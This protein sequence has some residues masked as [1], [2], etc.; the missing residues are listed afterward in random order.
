MVRKELLPEILAAIP[1]ADKGEHFANRAR[2]RTG[3]TCDG[4]IILRYSC[5]RSGY[6]TPF[7]RKAGG[8]GS[9]AG[10]MDDVDEAGDVPPQGGA[11]A[12]PSPPPSEGHGGVGEPLRCGCS[13]ATLVEYPPSR[14]VPWCIVFTVGQHAKGCD[15]ANNNR[16]LAMYQGLW[17]D[18]HMQAEPMVD[19]VIRRNIQLIGEAGLKATPVD[20]EP[21]PLL[22]AHLMVVVAVVGAQ[23]RKL[24]NLFD[25]CVAFRGMAVCRPPNSAGPGG[26]QPT[27]MRSDRRA[28]A[29]VGGAG[30]AERTAGAGA[31]V[32]APV[33]AAEPA[34]VDRGRAALAR[35][36][37]GVKRD[38]VAIEQSQPTDE[39]KANALRH[40]QFLKRSCMTQ[41]D[42]DELAERAELLPGGSAH[43]AAALLGV[44]PRYSYFRRAFTVRDV[45]HFG[46]RLRE[47]ARNGVSVR[48]HLIDRLQGDFA[49][50][51]W[52]KTAIAFEADGTVKMLR[53]LIVTPLMRY[54]ATCH[55]G[56]MDVCLLDSTFGLSQFSLDFFVILLIHP[57]T[58]LAL[59]AGIFLMLGGSHIESIKV[60]SMVL[61]WQWWRE[62]ASFI[63]PRVI[64]QDKDKGSWSALA[65]ALQQDCA[66][67]AGV[68]ALASVM[69]QLRALAEG[70]TRQELEAADACLQAYR[71]GASF[72]STDL[73]TLPAERVD[74]ARLL[75]RGE[76][77]ERHP[78]LVRAFAFRMQQTIKGTIERVAAAHNWAGVDAALDPARRLQFLVEAGTELDTFFRRFLVHHAMLCWFHAKKAILEHVWKKQLVPREQQELWVD[79]IFPA[80][81]KLFTCANEDELNELWADLQARYI[82]FPEMIKYLMDNWMC[83]EWRVMWA[84]P[85][86]LQVPHLLIN[87]TNACELFFNVM[88]NHV[89]GAR[90]RIDMVDV[91]RKVF[92]LPGEPS[93]VR[94]SMAGG[95]HLKLYHIMSPQAYLKRPSRLHRDLV[96]AVLAAIDAVPLAVQALDAPQGVYLVATQRKR[97]QM[98]AEAVQ[99]AGALPANGP[100]VANADVLGAAVMV[101]AGPGPDVVML[102]VAPPPAVYA[103]PAGFHICSVLTNICS[104]PSTRSPCECVLSARKLHLR[105]RRRSM[106]FDAELSQYYNEHP[107]VMA[108]P[109]ELD[110]RLQKEK[111]REAA[112]EKDAGLIELEVL[113][114]WLATVPALKAGVEHIQELLARLSVGRTPGAGEAE[115]DAGDEKELW[116]EKK[117]ASALRTG[118]QSVS[119]AI[120]SMLGTGSVAKLAN[121]P[122]DKSATNSAQVVSRARSAGKLHEPG[123]RATAYGTT[124]L[125]LQVAG[126]VHGAGWFAH[127]TGGSLLLSR[128]AGPAKGQVGAGAGAGSAR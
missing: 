4:A 125:A 109:N 53:S 29:A 42:W 72:S 43:V 115:E 103:A 35:H 122:L 6:S 111:A 96:S 33:P 118:I 87:T 54:F 20:K 123:V 7:S 26:V 89:L 119:R 40:A 61:M 71:E 36:A 57:P 9:W 55:P 24:D 14:M 46:D 5:L 78:T 19:L 98:A 3:E 47:M 69:S 82:Q 62:W 106:W 76:V 67:D 17:L 12:M 48:S 32:G 16:H 107:G 77:V 93:S 99:D 95:I 34:P 10:H 83:E 88:K 81:E 25:A 30:A 126:S 65:K 15:L 41:G 114:E 56:M 74:A 80:I 60:D 112:Q 11:G 22:R 104:C 59:P 44:S 110:S 21:H 92:G 120:Q 51:G 79:A 102:A 13:A 113:E 39:E 38:A 28:S 84:G 128:A 18:V 1:Y 45:Y 68:A 70:V 64:L 27:M 50:N 63:F 37:A 124:R 2:V 23:G 73:P 85:G 31:A 105:T 100:D 58:G 94:R 97:R 90:R 8:A 91:F 108:T 116:R 66:S 86:R 75:L 117:G 121:A 127:D 49:S 52:A 101:G